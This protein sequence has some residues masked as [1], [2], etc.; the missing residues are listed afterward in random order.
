ML[1]FLSVSK[2]T[3]RR[4]RK[5]LYSAPSDTKLNSLV[6]LKSFLQI[7][8]LLR[9]LRTENLWSQRSGT[10]EVSLSGLFTVQIL[11]FLIILSLKKKYFTKMRRTGEQRSTLLPHEAASAAENRKSERLELAPSK[12]D[13]QRNLARDERTPRRAGSKR[14]HLFDSGT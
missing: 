7:S 10:A 1:S 3:K 5:N 11:Q 6:L 8:L 9:V 4:N 12:D 14:D 13:D 2:R